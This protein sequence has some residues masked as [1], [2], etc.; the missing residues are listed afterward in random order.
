MRL[1]ISFARVSFKSRRRMTVAMVFT[2]NSIL[3]S[4]LAADIAPL[5]RTYRC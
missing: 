4:I 1:R 2:V 3:L 5:S